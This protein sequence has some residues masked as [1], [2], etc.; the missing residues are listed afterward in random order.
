MQLLF[1]GWVVI[2]RLFACAGIF[3]RHILNMARCRFL[4]M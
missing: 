3:F 2:L 4:W 1:G